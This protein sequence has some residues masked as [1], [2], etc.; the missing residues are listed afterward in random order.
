M[1]EQL[2]SW[3]ENLTPEMRGYILDGA[4]ALGALLGGHWL[5]KF[6]G[7]FLRAGRFNSLFRVTRQPPGGSD[8]DHFFTPTML[9]GLLVRLTVWA[10]AASWL[11]PK[12]GRP[13]LAESISSK[14]GPVWTVAA[15]LAAVLALAGLLARRV[16]ECL[17]GGTLPNRSGAAPTRSLA[18]A[19][20]AG[21]YAVVL[22]LTLVTAADY[23]DWPQTR[24]AAAGLW[25][26]ALHL[27][28]AGAAVLVGYVGVLW[29]RETAAQ[30]ASSGLQP[31]QQIA[32]GIVAV[33]T[34]L[35]VALLL[36][37]SGL[38]VGAAILAGAAGLLF[39]ARGRLPDVKA[40]L[41]LRLDRVGTV[42]FGGTPWQV[43]QI[44]VLRSRI[45][46]NGENYK[47]PNRQVLEASGPAPSPREAN[48]RPVLTR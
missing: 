36:F 26:L 21:I 15:A 7:R 17:E 27:L 23:F 11:L 4:V 25:Q 46:R 5:G 18:G 9:A 6:V 29:A 2:Q 45:S 39:L 3:W 14:I 33:T 48:G 42:W 37:G 47:V 34:G 35:A 19:V 1:L 16:I 32:L 12:Y 41:K 43:E 20:G 31:G 38:G 40:G 8:D 30:G 22:L 24:T 28:T 44:G 13:E 10:F